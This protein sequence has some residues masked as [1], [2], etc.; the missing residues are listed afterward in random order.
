MFLPRAA[1][2]ATAAA[3]AITRTQV[4]PTLASG[5]YHPYITL[6]STSSKRSYSSS[7]SLTEAFDDFLEEVG[8]AS[9]TKTATPA[10]ATLDQVASRQFHRRRW[11]W[12][13]ASKSPP[14]PPIAAPAPP[15]QQL[16]VATTEWKE[17]MEHHILPVGLQIKVDFS[18]NV[19]C[20]R[21]P[22]GPPPSAS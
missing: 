14:P 1:A 9:T 5:S 6:T 13:T 12:A 3:S 10:A 20:A 2:A 8:Q 16:F 19:A 11:N 7:S 4:L 17:V 22:P 18:T 21:L 15:R